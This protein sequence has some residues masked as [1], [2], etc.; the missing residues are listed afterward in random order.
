M[1]VT[2][3]G[4][5]PQSLARNAIH[6]MIY[7]TL[8]ILGSP[9]PTPDRNQ[10]PVVALNRPFRVAMLVPRRLAVVGDSGDSGP[11]A[12]PERIAVPGRPGTN[13]RN[14]DPPRFSSGENIVRGVVDLLQEPSARPTWG[15]FQRRT[16]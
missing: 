16:F 2:R 12:E 8:S 11:V 4:S 13:T 3:A 14:D 15:N 7:T 10:P 5:M 1:G 9:A 6:L